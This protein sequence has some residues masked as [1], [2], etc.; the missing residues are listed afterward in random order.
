MKISG[1]I[2]LLLILLLS[3][4]FG[5]KRYPSGLLFP[6]ELRKVEDERRMMELQQGQELRLGICHMNQQE[7]SEI[8]KIL[9]K[10][11]F[12]VKL[13]RCPEKRLTGLLRSGAVDLIHLPGA[14]EADAEIWNLIWIA[15]GL[16]TNN[17]SLKSR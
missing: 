11:N 15:P 14:T 4:C 12:K 9:N 10:M 13:V 1:S 7:F 6:A 17:Q 3:G 2:L 8:R 5:G 16:L